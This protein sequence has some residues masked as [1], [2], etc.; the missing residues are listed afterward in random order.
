LIGV[1]A[2]AECVR[3]LGGLKLLHFGACLV[4]GGDV[5]RKLHEAGARYPISGFVHP[6]DWS[7]S[8]IVDFTYLDLIL[9]RGLAPADAA[10]KTRSMMTFARKQGAEG[11]AIPPM[12]LVVVEPGSADAVRAG[13]GGADAN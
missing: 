2:L 3:D 8:A 12:G 10:E 6:A 9:S 11:D 1:D 7:G 4:A 13:P 5:P